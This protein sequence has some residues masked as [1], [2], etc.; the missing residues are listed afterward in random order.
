MVSEAEGRVEPESKGREWYVY[1]VECADGALYTGV[2]L[3]VH[4]RLAE[5]LSGQGSRYLNGKGPL[6]LRYQERCADQS[7]A[8]HREAQIKRWTRNKKLA[9]ISGDRGLLK[10]G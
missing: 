5:H 3:D 10:H 4:R 7:S 9:L 2:T 1:I 8:F 6:V